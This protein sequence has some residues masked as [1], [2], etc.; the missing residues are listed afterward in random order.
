M[1]ISSFLC[2]DSGYRGWS[3]GGLWEEGTCWLLEKTAV[4]IFISLD[5]NGEE[6]RANN[7]CSKV[8][9]LLPG[10]EKV[11]ILWVN[12]ERSLDSLTQIGIIKKRKDQ[13]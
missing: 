4:G 6:Q 7:R 11:V 13:L 10:A 9:L 2:W 5:R 8:F 12:T 1:T 3:G